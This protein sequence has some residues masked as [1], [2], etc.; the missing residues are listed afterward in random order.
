[1]E[2]PV[3]VFLRSAIL[4]SV[5]ALGFTHL[6]LAANYPACPASQ[7]SA[8]L[9]KWKNDATEVS[10]DTVALQIEQ[11]FP[12][13]IPACLERLHSYFAPHGVDVG[14]S[15]DTSEDFENMLLPKE[16]LA[17]GSAFNINGSFILY[18]G[19]P[20]TSTYKDFETIAKE[21]GWPTVRYKSRLGGGFDHTPSLLMVRITGASLN[22]PSNYDRYV[23]IPLPADP[24]EADMKSADVV[25]VPTTKIQ[26]DYSTEVAGDSADYPTTL[27]MVTLNKATR[28]G[29]P[30]RVLFNKFVRTQGSPFFVSQGPQS[31]PYCYSCHPNGAR[32]ISPLGYHVRGSQVQTGQ[33]KPEEM[34]LATQE[35]NNS[36][37]ANNGYRPAT[38]GEVKD[39]QGKLRKLLDP[40]AYG[41]L[42]GPVHPLNRTTT[43]DAQGTH[44]VYPTRTQNFIVGSDGKSGCAYSQTEIALKDT[45]APGRDNVY[46]M[47]PSL[48]VDWKKVKN[49]MT[50][51][52][53]HNN[54]IHGGL[55]VATN[56]DHIAFK[57]VGDQSMPMGL[58]RDP[59]DFDSA[60][61]TV[62]DALNGNERIALVSCLKAE[63]QLEN[64]HTTDWLK[65]V[66][67]S[68]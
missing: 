18:Q 53:C 6:A 24:G 3:N 50:C 7:N 43:T 42:Y 57:I 62:Q 27:T 12:N 9:E 52:S 15:T 1:M 2:N 21:R 30:S 61:A 20:G 56:F 63:F 16:F 29:K 28:D 45:R 54:V 38:W 4:V 67:C 5:A 41:P 51:A 34:W 36:M 19:V 40:V 60:T 31:L 44:V 11:C 39:S 32:A 25:P 8:E 58:H 48:P 13:Q 26:F 49:A 33:V 46:D 22:P 59:R 14:S 23:N 37:N 68:E 66:S 35:M 65:D 55:N 10:Q 17:P 64:G 47:D